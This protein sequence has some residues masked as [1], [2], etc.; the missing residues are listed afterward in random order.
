M[1]VK[2][3]FLDDNGMNDILNEKMVALQYVHISASSREC[4]FKLLMDNSGD[5]KS[6][7]VLIEH[8]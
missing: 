2:S 8:I 6:S 3:G 7:G 1:R 5:T 4:F